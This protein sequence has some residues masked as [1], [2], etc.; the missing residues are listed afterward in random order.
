MET[1]KTDN[2]NHPAHYQS[3]KGLETIDIIDACVENLTGMEAVCT[4]NIIKYISRWKKKN[5]LEDL[6]KAQWYL[7][8]LINTVVTDS[9]TIPNKNSL[10]ITQL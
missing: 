9:I 10:S 7:N 6:R 3:S 8:K 2:V 4:A 5:G 1:K